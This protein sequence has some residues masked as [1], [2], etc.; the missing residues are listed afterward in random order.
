MSVRLTFLGGLGEIGR[1]CAALEVGGKIA[2]ID[3]GLMFPQEDML[4]VDLVFP[5]WGWLVARRRDVT[6]VVLTHGHEDHIGALAYF[7]S[8][9]NVPV[10]GTPLSVELARGRI[11]ELGVQADLRGVHTNVWIEEGPFR[12]MFVAVSHSVPQGAAV[13]FDT[14]EGLIL[15]SGDFKLDATPIDGRPTDLPTFAELGRQGVRL[16]MADSTNAE[17]PGFV[18]SE[19]SLADPIRAI[20]REAPGRVI[21]AC[22]SS[23][24]HRIQQI[25]DAGIANG[26]QV[27]FIGRSLQR[28]IGVAQELGL[29]SLPDHALLDV[30]EVLK[31]PARHQLLMT[32]GSQGE[33]FAALSLISQGQHKFVKLTEGDTVLI[34]AEPIPGNELAVSRVISRLYRRGGRVFHGRNANVHVSGHANREELLTFINLIRPQAYVPVHGEY[35]HLHANALLARELGVPWVEAMEDGDS[36]LIEGE[37]ITIKRQAVNGGYV[38]LDGSGV[39][40]VKIGVLRDRSHLADEGVLVVTVGVSGQ[41]GEIVYG[42]DLD[43]HGLMDDPSAVLEKASQ[44]VRQAVEEI[45]GDHNFDLAALQQRVRRAA[46]K[47]V[48]AETSRRPVIIPVVVEL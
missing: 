21:A 26:R 24:L 31:L 33:P 9:I 22:F 47:V 28:N 8:D 6:C 1:N 25:V 34:S 40:D 2:L 3:C 15:H 7:L 48:R 4:G 17:K 41:S 5:D 13:A 45:A 46:A 20:L 11:D 14:D 16:L 39:G 44:A 19:R 12:F 29:I 27:A 38:Y 37:R 36:L 23:H 43:S 30:E 18:A 42:P 10:Y 35:R 32:T